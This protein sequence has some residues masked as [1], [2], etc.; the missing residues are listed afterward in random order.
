MKNLFVGD[1]DQYLEDLA[2]IKDPDAFLLTSDN[3]KTFITCRK[4]ITAY[5]SLGDLPKDLNIFNNLLD[6]AD[7]I[8]YCPS[9]EWKN[10]SE[11]N[12][13]YDY[14]TTMQGITELYILIKSKNKKVYGLE[15]ISHNHLTLDIDQKRDFDFPTL[16]VA[17]D[18]NTRAN[19]VEQEESYA[20]LLG[21]SLNMPTINLANSGTSLQ[22]SADRILRSD[23][24]PKDIV[25]WGLTHTERITYVEKNKFIKLTSVQ[26]YKYPDMKRILD[27]KYLLSENTLHQALISIEQVANFCKKIGV[28]FYCFLTFGTDH[29]LYKFLHDKPYFMNID[30]DYVIDKKKGSWQLNRLDYGYDNQHPGPIHHKFWHSEI[31]K[32][33]KL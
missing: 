18:S 19:Q 9:N 29:H 28:K 3:Y 13:L 27:P 10:N 1:V 20:Y 31:L 6:C 12:N 2:K 4:N 24:R 30:F 11:K 8:H 15:Y 25:I 5:T 33:I 22:W 14:T 7:E 16:W 21:Q 32:Y 26:Y 17:G 23:I